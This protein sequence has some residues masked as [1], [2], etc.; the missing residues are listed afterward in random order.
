MAIISRD[1]KKRATHSRNYER[2]SI[3]CPRKKISLDSLVSDATLGAM[4]K[5]LLA[6]VLFSISIPCFG[7]N[8]AKLR[9]AA[10]QGMLGLKTN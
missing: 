6:L 7:T 2:Q 10:E 9:K 8:L 4:I 5:I 1:W 3:A